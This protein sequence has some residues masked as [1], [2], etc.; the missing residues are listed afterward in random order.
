M[1]QITK[2]I[3]SEFYENS[4]KILCFVCLET[5]WILDYMSKYEKIQVISTKENLY[6]KYAINNYLNY[7]PTDHDFFIYYFHTKGLTKKENYYH[8]WRNILDLF[9][10][11]RWQLSKKLLDDY[12][13]VGIWLRRYPKI[14]FGG[15]FWWSKSEHVRK[16]PK[17]GNK[18]LDPEMYICDIP[19]TKPICIYKD[20]NEENDYCNYYKI[21]QEKEKLL[22]LSDES[23]I[24]NISNESVDNY[25]CMKHIFGLI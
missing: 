12:D 10:L 17:I 11:T 15:N 19:Q 1:E 22:L 14:H 16:L 25:F 24:Q 21:L 9:T 6:E 8:E 3:L 23:I 13:C 2:L 4:E 5:Q 20:Y 7:L 18:Y